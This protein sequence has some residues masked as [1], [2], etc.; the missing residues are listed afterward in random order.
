[1]KTLGSRRL[2]ESRDW[3]LNLWNRVHLSVVWISES[4]KS[5]FMIKRSRACLDWPQRHPYKTQHLCEAVS[6]HGLGRKLKAANLYLDTYLYMPSW[7]LHSLGYGVIAPITLKI[8]SPRLWAAQQTRSAPPARTSRASKML[9]KVR[10][11]ADALH[12][13]IKPLSEIYI[14]SPH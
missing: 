4:C 3:V 11:T 7:I 10:N 1:M 14:Y 9:S 6:L 2:G 12:T 8:N 5:A 13:M